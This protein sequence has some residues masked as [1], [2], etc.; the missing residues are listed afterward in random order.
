L[1][2]ADF[3]T[4]PFTG[5]AVS[6]IPTSFTLDSSDP[7][8]MLS[9]SSYSGL[10]TDPNTLVFIQGTVN[11]TSMFRY[12]CSVCP[13]PSTISMFGIG[14]ASVVFALRRPFRVAKSRSTDFDP[15]R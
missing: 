14:L 15:K 8:V 7:T 2:F 3:S 9:P 1:G 12:E 13:E 11:G 4:S 5:S 6:G 10:V